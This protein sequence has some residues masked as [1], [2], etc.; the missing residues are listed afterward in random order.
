MTYQFWKK[1]DLFNIVIDISNLHNNLLYEYLF[2]RA[3]NEKSFTGYD[4][5]LYKYL[6]SRI[7]N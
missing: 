2:S 1:E 5:L 7:S 6:F 4:N 3:S